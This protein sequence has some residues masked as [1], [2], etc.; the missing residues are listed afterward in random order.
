MSEQ[1][2]NDYSRNTELIWKAQGGDRAAMDELVGMNMGLIR[3]I[4]PRFADRGIEYEDLVQ[5]GAIGMIKAIKS[6]RAD[7]GT[8]FSTYAVPLIIGEIRRF[9]RDDGIIK[10]S[11][12]VKRT[13]QNAMKQKE[14]YFKPLLYLNEAQFL[15]I[16]FLLKR[17]IVKYSGEQSTSTL[18]LDSTDEETINNCVNS[19][20]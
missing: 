5:I 17:L 18:K 8:V 2:Q 15:Y 4:V 13:A 20:L 14:K 9:L 16:A 3:S 11:R 7:L 10:V 19:I 6:Y 1:K 12:T